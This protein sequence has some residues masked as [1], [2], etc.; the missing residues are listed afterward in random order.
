MVKIGCLHRRPP[1]PMSR[2]EETLQRALLAHPMSLPAC[3]L[4]VCGQDAAKCPCPDAC[5]LPEGSP[6]HWLLQ[7]V[8]RLVRRR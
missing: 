8:G 7:L 6:Q 1:P 3:T 4:N 5:V 2:D